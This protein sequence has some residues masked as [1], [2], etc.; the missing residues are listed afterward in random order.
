MNSCNFIVLGAITIKFGIVKHK[1]FSKTVNKFFDFFQVLLLFSELEML[2]MA[3]FG[4]S[5][6]AVL[7]NFS[8][9]I[10]KILGKTPS[11]TCF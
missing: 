6:V 2:K 5:P 7:D 1:V 3:Q 10:W 9:K 8:N 11:N 4:M